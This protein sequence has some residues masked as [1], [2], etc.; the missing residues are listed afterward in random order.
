MADLIDVIG[1]VGQT[2]PL[3]FEADEAFVG[4][5]DILFT[6]FR[7]E[8]APGDAT[9]KSVPQ[10]RFK[11]SLPVVPS[12]PKKQGKTPTAPGVV[13]S[14]VKFL[15]FLP[16]PDL[17]SK[18]FTMTFEASGK[19]ASGKTQRARSI[20][21]LRVPGIA[22]TDVPILK[23]IMFHEF[24][25]AQG[26]DFV[27]DAE[28]LEK[29][30]AGLTK[31]QR[32]LL[33]TYDLK[34]RAGRLVC[35]VTLTGNAGR[36]MFADSCPGGERA[37]DSVHANATFSVFACRGPGEVA[38]LVCH[39]A[40]FCVNMD[41]PNT[42]AFF[43]T[44]QK[45][46]APVEWLKTN[47]ETPPRFAVASHSAPF[48]HGVIYSRVF[49]VG[50]TGKDIMKG[51]TV[52]GMINTVG[53]WMIFRNFNWP[54]SKRD[55][56][57]RIYSGIFRDNDPN[58]TKTPAALA[59]LGYDVPSSST[60]IGSVNKWFLGDR[61]YAYNFFFRH[62]VGVEFFAVRSD[63]YDRATNFHNPHGKVFEPSLLKSELTKDVFLYHDVVSRRVADNNP[64]FTP[65]DSLWVANAVG[66]KTADGFLND[67]QWKQNLPLPV[68][69]KRSWADWYFYKPDGLSLKDATDTTRGRLP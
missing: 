53:C 56:F 49:A 32:M 67:G 3:E 2:V 66:F 41:N 62:V 65:P 12:K 43:N 14:T 36:L 7:L 22:V 1:V 48:T 19:A 45:G 8:G 59:A 30:I 5:I 18:I 46:K 37:P 25:K 61:N 38:T 17:A 40:H 23:T 55:A 11:R 42:S 9:R 4:S 54:E 10:S 27:F 50:G 13:R 69:E 21:R 57:F 52:H 26:K 51:N 6:V 39:T 44:P 58:D 16:F 28:P 33:A 24:A 60:V 47:N 63:N 31:E 34:G 29:V 15:V 20:N 68:L 35:F 64:K